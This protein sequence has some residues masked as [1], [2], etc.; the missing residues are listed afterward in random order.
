MTGDAGPHDDKRRLKFLIWHLAAYFAV[1]VALFALN[2]LVFRNVLWF[3]IPMLGWGGVI[4][5]HTAYV[6]GL[7]DR[8]PS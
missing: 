5:I 6:M 3:F 8:G 2:I 1:V 7:F 4:A